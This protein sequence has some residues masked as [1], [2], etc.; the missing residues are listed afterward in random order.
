M[1]FLFISFF[2]AYVSFD[3]QVKEFVQDFELSLCHFTFC[4]P[5][6]TPRVSIPYTSL[7]CTVHC[8]F[9]LAAIK[10]ILYFQK[11][12]TKSVFLFFK[13]KANIKFCQATKHWLDPTT[14][15]VSRSRFRTR[16]QQFLGPGL[17]SRSEKRKRGSDLYRKFTKEKHIQK[18]NKNIL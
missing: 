10:K 9:L 7:S 4:H 15:S 1:L 6:V 12:L 13:F 5:S 17:G 2:K 16:Q 18:V 11:F 8:P 14:D 3:F